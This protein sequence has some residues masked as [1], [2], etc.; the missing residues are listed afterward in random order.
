MDESDFVFDP[1]EV[2]IDMECDTKQE[3]EY[4]KRMDEELDHHL[5]RMHFEDA[6]EAAGITPPVRMK[7][8]GKVHFFHLGGKESDS[9]GWYSFAPDHSKGVFGNLKTGAG[10]T[11]SNHDETTTK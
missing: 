3:E 4:W 10:G 2:E 5:N 7:D 11:W 6:M 1:L 8:D 9:L